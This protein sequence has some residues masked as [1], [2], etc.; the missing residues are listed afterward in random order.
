MHRRSRWVFLAFALV[1]SAFSVFPHQHEGLAED[2][3]AP[4]IERIGN[5]DTPNVAH[6]HSA[7][8]VQSQPCVACE[9]QRVVGAL[10]VAPAPLERPAVLVAPPVVL[11]AP[12]SVALVFTPLRAPPAA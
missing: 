6:F 3:F 11:I 10:R 5:C 8:Q 1:L 4:T 12:A 7:R 9:R 2:L